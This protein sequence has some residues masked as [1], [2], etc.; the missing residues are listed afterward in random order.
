MKPLNLIISA[1]GPYAGHTFIPFDKLGNQ[2]IYLITGDTGA[3]KTTIFD[4]ISYALYGEASGEIREANMFRSKYAN[5]D[6]PTF[7]ELEFEYGGKTYQIRRNPEYERPSKKGNKRTTQKASVEL[8]LPGGTVLTNTKEVNQVLKEIMGLD[9]NQFAQISMIAQG[10]FLKLILASTEERQKIF[11]EIF[12][13]KNYQLI[14]NRLKEREA[15]LKKNLEMLKEKI[16]HYIEAILPSD[17]KYVEQIRCAK[18]NEMPIEEIPTLLEEMIEYDTVE[19]KKLK[20]GMVQVEQRLSQ[21]SN[22]LS[23]LQDTVRMKN[24]LE[25]AQNKSFEVD[26]KKKEVDQKWERHQKNKPEMEKIAR[27]IVLLKEEIPKYDELD[28]LNK[29]LTLLKEEILQEENLQEKYFLAIKDLNIK[30]EREKEYF[31]K[32]KDSP[33]KLERMIRQG[34]DREHQIKDLNASLSEMIN[35]EKDAE[36]IGKLQS[37]YLEIRGRTDDVKKSYDRMQ[38]AY[39]DE[40]AG[41]LAQNL[42][43][44]SPCPVCGSKSHPTLAVLSSNAPSREELEAQKRSV[45]IFQ[46][47]MSKKSEDLAKIIASYGSKCEAFNQ[48]LNAFMVKYKVED[49][50]EDF[51]FFTVDEE[52]KLVFSNAKNLFYLRKEFLEKEMQDLKIDIMNLQKSVDRMKNLEREI[53]NQEKILQDYQ[54][55]IVQVKESLASKGERKKVWEQ[56]KSKLQEILKYSGKQALHYKISKLEVLEK[57]LKKSYQDTQDLR[58]ELVQSQAELHSKVKTLKGELAQY[59]IPDSV[60][61]SDEKSFYERKKQEYREDLDKKSIRLSQN[62]RALEG[63]MQYGNE[64]SKMREY[65]SMVKSL[66][67]T[68]NGNVSGK[69]K[70]MLE[71]Y[72][73]TAYFERIISG[74]NTRFMQMSAGQYELKRRLQAQNLRSQTGLELDVVDHYNGSVRDVR[75]LSGGESFKASLAL[76]LGLS[77]EVQ[78]TSGGIRIDSMYI[79]EG[80]GSLDENSLRQAI[81]TLA[82]LSDASRLIGIISHVSELKERIE[83][84]IVVTKNKTGGSNVEIIV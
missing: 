81:D 72:I 64:L 65:F 27:D 4:A 20:E 3:G 23:K 13:T 82:S 42:K 19:L 40:Q 59:V 22:E 45:E 63:I 35:L 68:V 54:E 49:W 57:K 80:F 43:D 74:A 48:K 79:D 37:E 78:S 62:K 38:R 31:E 41:L 1:F 34:E 61:L 53:P 29:N 11:R 84:Q 51:F 83:K 60:K 24:S 15:D 75:S 32:L 56:S 25:E 69:E 2:G 17:E 58:N 47:E 55:K 21:I 8:K 67:N 36:T 12:F 7:V 71:T 9:K 6:I 76:A 39:F 5:D 33:I 26:S 50:R 73:Q 70:I 28:Y 30:I 18:N 66:S 16:S 14:Q 52:K 46:T 77:D 44:D 10:E